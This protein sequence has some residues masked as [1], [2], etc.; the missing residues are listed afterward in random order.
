MILKAGSFLVGL[1]RKATPKPIK[2]AVLAQQ[3]DADPDGV[4]FGPG[5]R[6]EYDH[7]P[8]LEFRN[9]DT[10]AGDFIPPQNSLDYLFAIRKPDHDL[11]TFGRKPGA[12]ITVTT[13]D[14]DTGEAA[15]VRDIQASD[16]IHR[17]KIASKQG[18]YKDAA[19]ILAAV[20]KRRLKPK[21]KIRSNPTI[22]S[23]GFDR[24]H[25]PMRRGA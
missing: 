7:D 23:R 11:K 9:Y 1:Y 10:I 21:K 25:R 24:G 20:P 14:S 3:R 22:Q 19:L 5:V 16:A 8:A 2:R 15:R 6:I 4:P 18:R 12:A 13:R 17:A